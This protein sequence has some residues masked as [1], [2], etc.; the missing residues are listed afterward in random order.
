MAK[1]PIE[2]VQEIRKRLIQ[3]S[4]DIESISAQLAALPKS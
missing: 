4:T 3:T 2:V 1:A